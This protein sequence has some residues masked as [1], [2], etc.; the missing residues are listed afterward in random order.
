LEAFA[1]GAVDVVAK[2]SG[3]VSQDLRRVERELIDKARAAVRAKLKRPGMGGRRQHEPRPARSAA[4][5]EPT[6][7]GACPGLVLIGVSTGGP[8]TLEEILPL[9]PAD[10]PYPVLVGIH[11]PAQF[12]GTFAARIDQLCALRVV[13]VSRT[14]KLSPGHVY[15]AR[16]GADMIVAQHSGAIAAAAAPPLPS[17]P[18]QPSIDRLV[19]SAMRY[20]KPEALI[21]VQL[22]G[23]GEDGAAA[24]K[25]LHD[26]GGRT[27]A[28]SEETAVVFGMPRELIERRGASC[29]LPCDL[30]A[31]QIVKWLKA[32]T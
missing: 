1:L 12:T 3:T 31:Q 6:A 8:R 13:E 17:S 9:L 14:T 4:Q 27:I 28:E 2:P 18:W 5:T 29:V 7:E 25:A 11:M 30:I 24:M 15:I 26:A 22:T 32:R 23:M 19:T 16:G 20:M 21:G 10:L